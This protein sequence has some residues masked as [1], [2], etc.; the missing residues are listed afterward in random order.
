MSIL[1]AA[2]PCDEM[3]RRDLA[4]GFN[5]RSHRHRTD[6]TMASRRRFFMAGRGDAVRGWR[7][8]DFFDQAG[9]N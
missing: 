5:A 2:K 1:Q 7:A 8:I 9:G 6:W 4:A 3:K